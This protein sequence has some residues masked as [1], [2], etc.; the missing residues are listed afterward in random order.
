VN[1][2][3]DGSGDLNRVIG[4]F[5]RNLSEGAPNPTSRTCMPISV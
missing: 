2:F 3:Y 5:L 1:L 4:V